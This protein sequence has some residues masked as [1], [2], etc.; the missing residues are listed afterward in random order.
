VNLGFGDR[1]ARLVG[2]LG[3]VVFDY[4]SSAQWELIFL[5]VGLWSVLTSVAGHC[6]FYSVMGIKTCKV[7]SQAE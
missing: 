7:D 2:G 1:V 3:F 5:V 4:V 6:P